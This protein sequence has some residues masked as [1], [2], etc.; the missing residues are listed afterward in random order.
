VGLPSTP[1]NGSPDPEILQWCEIRKFFLVTNNRHSMPVHLK[2]HLEAGR[3]VPGIIQLNPKLSVG[4]NIA[5]LRLIWELGD[6]ND[7]LDSIKYLS[8]R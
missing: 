4:D 6:E 1:P 5:Q 2:R 7:Y 8:T 3:H